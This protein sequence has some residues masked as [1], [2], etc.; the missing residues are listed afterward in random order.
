MKRILIA[1]AAL[2]VL[3]ACATKPDPVEEVIE[4]PAEVETPGPVFEPAPEV[5]PPVIDQ[6]TTV[7]A[8]Q[9][10]LPTPGSIE[11]FAYQAGG[12]PRVFFGYDQFDL[13]PE[14]RDVLR[15]QANWLSIYTDATAV[16]EGHADERGTREYNLALGAR[17]ADSVK[18]FLVSQGVS[19]NRLKTIS[20]GKERPIDARSTESGWARNRNGFTSLRLTNIS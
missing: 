6:P 19:P 10:N 12:E 9:V 20:Y 1:S 3:S 11:D 8:P 4:R 16:I 14:A 17:R 2:L 5:L 13:S 7:E 15:R 18:S